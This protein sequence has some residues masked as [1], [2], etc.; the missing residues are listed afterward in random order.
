MLVS[1]AMI[2]TMG[3]VWGNPSESFGVDDLPRIP[4]P[5]RSQERNMYRYLRGAGGSTPNSASSS[6]SETGNAT[7][8]RAVNNGSGSSRATEQDRDPLLPLPIEIESPGQSN[9]QRSRAATS[10]NSNRQSQSSRS[11]SDSSRSATNSADGNA[12]ESNRSDGDAPNG[13]RTSGQNTQN[14]SSNRSAPETNTNTNRA[15]NTSR[16]T[17]RSQTEQRNSTATNANSGTHNTAPPQRTAAVTDNAAN[18]L[19]SRLEPT[20]RGPYR[21]YAPDFYRGIY[22]TS[23]TARTPSRY[24]PLLDQAKAHGINVLVVDAQPYMPDAEFVR[25]AREKGFYLV[26]R[27]VVFEGGL[28]VFP[29][30]MK[31]INN[32]IDVAE[33]S[34]KAGFMEVQLDYIRFTDYWRGQTLSLEQRY[35]VITGVLKMA[36]DRLRPHGVRI[37]A[38]IFGRIAFNRNDRIGQQL[39]LFSEHLDTIYPMLYPSH[40]YGEPNR[41]RDPYST[42]LLG[43]K[44]SVERVNQRSRVIAYIQGFQMKISESGLSFTNYMRKQIEAS[45]DSGGAGF[46]CWNARNA[47]GP[48]FQALALHDREHNREANASHAR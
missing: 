17:D 41:I 48:F 39:E 15:T 43:V 13:Y 8:S 21:Y 1:A 6:N 38:D 34:V 14:H 42:I 7:G 25:L 26:S 40:F 44:N 31:H 18:S 47:Y 33:N 5:D 37:G 4:G 28:K 46:I 12:N 11:N 3:T 35:R 2:L 16:G 29:P 45:E 32:V 23:Y 9:R 24:K 36:T 10:E 22:L 30:D 19:P 20:R 27:V